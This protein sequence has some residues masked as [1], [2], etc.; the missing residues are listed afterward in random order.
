MSDRK[1]IE[2][3]YSELSGLKNENIIINSKIEQ[4]YIELNTKIDILCNFKPAQQ[5][6]TN[7]SDT[8]KKPLSKQ[9]YIKEKIKENKDEYIDLLYTEQEYLH[10]LE[11]IEKKNIKSKKTEEEKQ[12]QLNDYLY[13]EIININSEY[14][15]TL[16]KI[17][18]E[19]KKKFAEP[20]VIEKE[21]YIDDDDNEESKDNLE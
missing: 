8:K 19:Y 12:K 16:T 4:L 20:N 18:N 1:L 5:K 2:S 13:K 6:N 9:I 15:K 14:K 3:I 10:C 17:Y 11:I 21:D 7:A